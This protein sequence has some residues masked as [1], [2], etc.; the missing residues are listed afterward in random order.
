MAIQPSLKDVANGRLN[1]VS[2]SEAITQFKE[3]TAQIYDAVSLIGSTSAAAAKTQLHEGKAK[4]L[5]I[6]EKAEA[7]VKAR[8]LV[9]VGVAFAAGWL[10]SRLLQR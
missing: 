3:A 8:P 9:T 7:L 1:E 10:V 5:E 6:E 2:I 4:A